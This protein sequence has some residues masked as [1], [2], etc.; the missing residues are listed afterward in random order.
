MKEACNSI[1][2]NLKTFLRAELSEIKGELSVLRKDVQ[3]VKQKIHCLD[4]KN[5]ETERLKI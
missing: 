4:F 5:S 1:S 3:N 2:D